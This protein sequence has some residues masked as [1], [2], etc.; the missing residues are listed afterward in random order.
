MEYTIDAHNKIL[1]RLAV[2]IAIKLR[3]KDDPRFDPSRLSGNRVVVKNTDTIRV[4]G[5]KL[6][7]KTYKHHSGFHGGLKQEMLRDTLRRDSRLALRRAVMGM[8]PKNRLRARWIKNLILIR[9]E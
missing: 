1:G 3:G 5:K 7:Q 6:I 9:E 2:E 8:L 4:S